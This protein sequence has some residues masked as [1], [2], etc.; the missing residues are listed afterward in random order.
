MLFAQLLSHRSET[1]VTAIPLEQLAEK[2][3]SLSLLSLNMGE[4]R[5]VIM[6]NPWYTLQSSN[7]LSG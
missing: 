1:F 7:V 6:L 4:G 3:P 5:G 2:I